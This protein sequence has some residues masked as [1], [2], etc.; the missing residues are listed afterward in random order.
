LS[1]DY[2][3]ED[4]S[5]PFREGDEEASAKEEFERLMKTYALI[6]NYYHYEYT[7]GIWE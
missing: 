6:S 2:E 5:I 7:E 1:G 3:G 4:D